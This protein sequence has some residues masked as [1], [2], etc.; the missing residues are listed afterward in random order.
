MKK[1]NLWHLGPTA[2]V[3]KTDLL[4]LKKAESM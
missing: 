3:K 1:E 4:V 2:K